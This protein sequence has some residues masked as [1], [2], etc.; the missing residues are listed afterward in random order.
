MD[1]LPALLSSGLFAGAIAMRLQVQYEK[2]LE[3]IKATIEELHR[4]E[5]IDD[6]TQRAL[7]ALRG[8]AE[9]K[10]LYVD[11]FDKGHLSERAFRQLL[12]TL[13]LQ[14]DTVR[15]RGAYR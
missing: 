6:D 5:L 4:T 10:S 15:N 11:M 7:L 14:I 8:L 1:R 13:D 2:Q 12:L 3:S 9:E